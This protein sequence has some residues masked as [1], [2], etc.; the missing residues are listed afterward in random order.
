MPH[1]RQTYLGASTHKTLCIMPYSHQGPFVPTEDCFLHR[2]PDEL[3]CRILGYLAPAPTSHSGFQYEPCLP[4][5]LVCRRWERVYSSFLYRNIDLGYSGWQKP[6]RIRQLEATLRQRPDLCDA[7]RM[8]D[9]QH[10]HPSDATCEMI[11]DILSYAK[12]LRN[13]GLHTKYTQSTWQILNAAKRA[14]LARLKLSGCEGGPSLQMILKHFSLPTL[15]EVSVNNYGLGNEDEPGADNSLDA[16]Q[17]EL[18]LLLSSA[19]PCNVTTMELSE[20]IATTHVTKSFLQWPARLTSLT[21]RSCSYWYTI[22]AVQEMLD[23]HRHKLQHISLPELAPGFSD[24]PD[25][26]SFT[27]LETLQIHGHNL[28]EEPSCAAAA[29]LSA[30]RLRHLKISFDTED[31]HQ[32][33]YEDFEAD[34]IDWLKDFVGYITPTTHSLETVFVE[35]EPEVSI[36]DRNWFDIATWPWSYIEQAVG[37]FAGHNVTMTYTQP[38][39]SR[40]E[41]DLAVERAKEEADARQARVDLMQSQIRG[42]IV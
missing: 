26:S 25:F 17:Q 10:N 23:D 22:D 20:P 29:Q 15:K 16:T 12:G 18:D 13:F 6:R 36:S 3:L 32:T 35:F 27:S 30:P 19:S 41:W 42:V 7:V 4:I 34:R 8:V 21:M 14:P 33:P 40:K 39:Y 38:H 31:Q 11:A 9:F 5:S 37:L 2:M 1:L 28:F 24:L